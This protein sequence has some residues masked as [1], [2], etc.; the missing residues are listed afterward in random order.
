M[1]PT[2][3]FFKVISWKKTNLLACLHWFYIF[4]TDCMEA[5]LSGIYYQSRVYRLL[6]CKWRIVLGLQEWA[7]WLSELWHEGLRPQPVPQA[8]RHGVGQLF[9]DFSQFCVGGK[10]R[11]ARALAPRPLP[12][13]LQP[14]F[15]GEPAG[16]AVW[17][18]GVRRSGHLRGRGRAGPSV[19]WE[20]GF[21]GRFRLGGDSDFV[22]TLRR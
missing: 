7:A 6:R 1:S 8:L 10:W 9:M 14:P 11:P 15:C 20:R 21:K 5:L 22:L 16:A 13:A 2:T 4:F 12:G 18:R 19:R 3:Y 17:R